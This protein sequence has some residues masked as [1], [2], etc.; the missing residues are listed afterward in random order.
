MGIV[1][2]PFDANDAQGTWHARVPRKSHIAFATSGPG[3][4]NVV[5]TVQH[6][7]SGR[8]A[9]VVVSGQV[10]APAIDS[11]GFQEA[12]VIGIPRSWTINRVEY[13]HGKLLDKQEIN[14][15]R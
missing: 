12:D 3:T 13:G 6:A 15:G 1:S 14:T 4:T 5:T 7:L 9:L 8:I 10:T 2:S 11:D